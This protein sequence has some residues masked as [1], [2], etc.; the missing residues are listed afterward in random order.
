MTAKV[1]STRPT[2]NYGTLFFLI[3]MPS[4]WFDEGGTNNR[5]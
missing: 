4:E 5:E 2:N 1:S 3:G